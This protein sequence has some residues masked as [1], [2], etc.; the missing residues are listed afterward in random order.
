MV[1]HD[2]RLVIRNVF[3][4]HRVPR[5]RVFRV[6][7]APAYGRLRKAG[8]VIHLVSGETLSASAF[9]QTPLDSDGALAEAN[10]I[11]T[12]LITGIVPMP[13]PPRHSRGQRRT[14]G[15]TWW[16]AWLMLV[17]AAT[18]FA[19]LLVADAIINPYNGG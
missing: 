7:P 9:A 13:T 8:L 4:S 1:L 2:D 14:A 11:S 15:A 3:Q 10:L 17:G 19:V 5:A 12:W 6:D 16:G 18:I